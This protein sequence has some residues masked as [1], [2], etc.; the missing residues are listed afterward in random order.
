MQ[1]HDPFA[2]DRSLAAYARLERRFRVA[3]AEGTAEDHAF[4]VLPPGFS[5]ERLR[6]LGRD[7]ADAFEK[8]A[9]R[10][11]ARLL[12]EHALITER[13][14]LAQAYLRDARPVDK[15]DQGPFT[16]AE[17]FGRSLS[18][19]P[20]R[21][22]WLDALAA[23]G[24]EVGA[25]R[26]ALLE[27]LTLNARE[28]GADSALAVEPAPVVRE[29]G[30]AFMAATRDALRELGMRSLAEWIALGLGTDALGDWPVSLNASRLGE[31]FREG[32][33]L[34]GLSPELGRTPPMLGSSSGLRALRGFGRA[35][36]DAGASP[37]RPF[38]LA[39]D[40]YGLRSR[41]YG[42]LFALLPFHGSFAER[43]LGVGRGR[44]SEYR[45]ALG[46]VLLLS[47]YSA[48]ARAELAFAAL[49]GSAAYRRAFAEQLPELLGFEVPP[50][51]AGVVFVDEQAPRELAALFE[52]VAH[53]HTLTERHDEDW[54]RNPR[55]IE[56]LRG[57]I[58]ALPE[59]EVNASAVERGG[60][61]LSGSL[62]ASG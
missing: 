26:I 1:H 15:P 5:K 32:R 24:G 30:A 35:F 31:W 18:D 29:A 44:F 7:Q 9:A 40:P 53:D 45:R 8:A 39:R 46:R 19:A 22:G 49:E 21:A 61:L 41:R 20:R 60:R 28:L 57:D 12:L 58:E 17:L 6:E 43:K 52:A 3:L 13:S 55:A 56:E 33:W 54:F 2:L 37:R 42:A 27:A 25:R 62:L 14:A 16:V 38:A 47:A 11:M 48:V 59:L 36:H 50:R 51:L 4:E 10:W 23:Q 34:D